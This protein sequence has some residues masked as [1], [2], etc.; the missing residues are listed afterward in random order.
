MSKSKFPRMK[1]YLKASDLDTEGCV[2]LAAEVLRG[3]AAELEDAARRNAARPTK[4]NRDHLKKCRDFYSSPWFAAL[5][6]GL[7]DGEKVADQIVRSALRGAR[8]N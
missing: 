2:S 4:E 1:D 8:F 7:V 5:S 3:A 6:C